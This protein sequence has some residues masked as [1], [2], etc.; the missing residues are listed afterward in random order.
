MPGIRFG[1]NHIQ[2]AACIIVVPKYIRSDLRFAGASHTLKYHQA[3]RIS[4]EGIAIFGTRD[5]IIFGARGGHVS[6]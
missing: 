3:I 2:L 4:G 5:S 1:D 6:G